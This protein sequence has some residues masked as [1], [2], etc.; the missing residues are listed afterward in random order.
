MFSKNYLDNGI[1]IRWIRRTRINGAWRNNVEVPL[2]ENECKYLVNISKGSNL[3]MEYT[4]KS[5]VLFIPYIEVGIK[6]RKELNNS[7]E[8]I[9]Q[10]AQFSGVLGVGEWHI[11]ESSAMHS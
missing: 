7:N 8:Y 4:T 10:I 3:I 1:E 11:I 6:D 2:C 9:V 5:E